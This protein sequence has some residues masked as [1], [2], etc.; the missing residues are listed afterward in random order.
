MLPAAVLL[1]GPFLPPSVQTLGSEKP[2]AKLNKSATTGLRFSGQQFA[3]S[4]KNQGDQQTQKVW[5]L[6]LQGLLWWKEDVH[7]LFCCFQPNLNKEIQKR[8]W[9]LMYEREW[10]PGKHQ[11]KPSHPVILHTQDGRHSFCKMPHLKI[12]EIT[13]HA[14][15]GQGKRN[16]EK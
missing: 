14:G 6:P 9:F 4:L 16:T 7:V 1:L 8:Q 15:E 13:A 2:P 5:K 3:A 12:Y 10:S 11:G